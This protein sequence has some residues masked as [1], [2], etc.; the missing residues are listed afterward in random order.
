MYL[1]TPLVLSG[2]SC[3]SSVALYSCGS[4]EC[5]AVAIECDAIECKD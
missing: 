2:N 4:V 1:S 5:D 3:I